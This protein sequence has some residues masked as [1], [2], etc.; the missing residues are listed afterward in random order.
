MTFVMTPDAICARETLYGLMPPVMV[1]PHG[2]HVSMVVV[3]LG[4]MRDVEAV[5]AGMRQEVSAP[6]LAAE[7]R[8][9]Q[10]NQRCRWCVVE[11]WKAHR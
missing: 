8:I 1:S 6:A 11:Q 9:R 2:S 5:G 10:R 3:T 4:V 7:S